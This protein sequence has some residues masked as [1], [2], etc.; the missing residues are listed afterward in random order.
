MATYRIAAPD[1]KTYQIT[2][3]DGASNDDVRAEV[4]RQN[5]HLADAGTSDNKTS[6]PK[7][8]TSAIA[9]FGH[10][11]ERGVLPGL[12][13]MGGMA[14]GAAFGAG[15]GVLGGPAAPV[16]VPLGAVAF[17]LLGGLGA[18]YAT[19]AA[20]DYA[21]SKMPETAKALGQDEAQRQ[22]ETKEHPYASFAGELAP[23][24]LTLRPGSTA[25]RAGAGALERVLTKPVTGRVFGGTVGAGLEAGR[26]N[27]QGQPLDPYQIAMAGGTGAVLT[28]PTRMGRSIIRG[29]ERVVGAIPGMGARGPRP[30]PDAAPG[31]APAEP[32][33][34]DINDIVSQPDIVAPQDIVARTAQ[35]SVEVPENVQ[36]AAKTELTLPKDLAGAKPKYGYGTKQFDVNFDSDVDKAAYIAS[37]PKPSARDADYVAWASGATGM[38]PAEV[39]AH[40]NVIRGIIKIHAK[41]S[42]PGTVDMPSVWQPAQPMAAERGPSLTAA[43][44]GEPI[45]SNFDPMSWPGRTDNE[46]VSKHVTAAGVVHGG[47]SAGA[48]KISQTTINGVP[49]IITKSQTGGRASVDA[50]APYSSVSMDRPNFPNSTSPSELVKIGVVK[51]AENGGIEHVVVSP[52]FQRQGLATTLVNLSEKHIGVDVSKTSDISP[53]GAAFLENRRLA[54][55]AQPKMP[56]PGGVP[57]GGTVPPGAVPPGAVPPGAMPPSGMPQRPNTP[58]INIDKLDVEQPV[59]NFVEQ[60]AAANNDYMTQRRGIRSHETTVEAAKNAGITE[61]I[62][63][64]MK[65]GTAL[66]AEQLTQARQ[67]HANLAVTATELAKTGLAPTATVDDHIRFIEALT[68]H[69]PIAAATAGA[70]GESARTLESLKYNVTGEYQARALQKTIE[71]AKINN[72]QQTIEAARINNEQPTNKLNELIA[73]AKDPAASDADKQAAITEFNKN[74]KL[75]LQDLM[76]ATSVLDDPDEV[77]KLLAASQKPA[78]FWSKVYEVWINGLLSNVKTQAFNAIS[79]TLS[80]VNSIV[81][82][83]AIAAFSYAGHLGGKAVGRPTPAGERVYMG[84]TPA[85]LFGV[86]QGAK[87]SGKLAIKLLLSDVPMMDDSGKV[88]GRQHANKGMFGYIVRTPG[89]ALNASDA[90]FKGINYRGEINARAYRMAQAEKLSGEAFARRV[91]SLIDQPTEAMDKAGH[92]AAKYST[93][94]NDL[95]SMGQKV[96]DV[97]HDS[98]LGRVLIPFYR[99]T[100]NLGKYGLARSPL[101]FIPVSLN[102]VLFKNLIGRNGPLAAAE[103]RG[104]M[105]MGTMIS[106]AA[107]AYAM[108]ETNTLDGTFPVITGGGPNDPDQRK[109]LAN[110]GVQPYSFRWRG[111]YYSWQRVEPIATLLG[112]AADIADSYRYSKETNVY[113]D[114]YRKEKLKQL[115]RA[116]MNNITNKTWLQSVDNFLQ[117]YDDPD[118]KMEPFIRQM[119]G[120]VVPGFIASQ[121]RSQDPYVRDVQSIQDAIK[122]RL[123]GYSQELAFKRDTYGNPIKTKQTLSP[124]L[125]LDVSPISKDPALTEPARLGMSISAPDRLQDGTKLTSQQYDKY[126]AINN[127]LFMQI[128][129]PRI[130]SPAWPKYSDG[131]KRVLIEILIPTIRA[132]A[133]QMLLQDKSLIPGY[134]DANRNVKTA[135]TL[136][137]RQPAPKPMSG[138]ERLVNMLK[139]TYKEYIH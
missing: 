32:R 18:G 121:A 25:V 53:K 76:K 17:G 68:A 20:Q 28:H 24:L 78:T 29:S 79:N 69:D 42:E 90:F 64:S 14:G 101:G 112:P 23:Q 80:T 19:N 138:T 70:R 131:M 43:V 66:N 86:V 63:A 9:A 58:S 40:G 47:P 3:P 37:Q 127:K 109:V 56:P 93:F 97:I 5:P 6:A 123:P 89:R 8:K 16:T 45:K 107:L 135:I 88:S 46:Y 117:A 81:E 59:K 116:V 71:D 115:T 118:R 136:G 82:T 98:V 95:G 65:P 122:N 92:E 34:T 110:A 62:L 77:A 49:I 13:G 114:E 31:E 21:L 126:Q 4:I 52:E 128:V 41:D 36:P 33:P 51:K 73:R 22:L 75:N 1:G 57:P 100:V 106:A 124:F 133:S 87:D 35:P 113:S 38:S 61:E 137:M 26:E 15:L 108:D 7:E 44:P 54:N 130:R 134:I 2:G 96:Q 72:E 99:T 83:P 120:S 27:L 50:Y 85:R 102:P 67:I 74:N 55:L 12:A 103:A 132:R 11:A 39:R 84:E 10:G 105:A 125:P 129:A 139:S 48:T 91:K 111:K 104:R 94:T 119:A 30:S 60:Q